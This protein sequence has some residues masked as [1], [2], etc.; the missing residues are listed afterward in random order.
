VVLFVPQYS[1]PRLLFILLIIATASP[2]VGDLYLP[3]LPAIADE[4]VGHVGLVKLSVSVFFAGLT[5]SILFFGPLS[6]HFERKHIIIAGFGLT[7]LATI[8]LVLFANAQS[9]IICRFIQGLGM[10]ATL[11]FRPMMRE[12]YAKQQLSVVGSYVAIAFSIT[13]MIIPIT[14][15]VIQELFDWQIN[16]IVLT[17]YLILV[18]FLI[19]WLLDDYKGKTRH[20]VDSVFAT[21]LTFI[22]NKS[23]MA[24]AFCAA[25]SFSSF[26]AYITVGPFIFQDTLGL[27]PSQ[28][29]L[30]SIVIVCALTLSS[31]LNKKW[32]TLYPINTVIMFGLMMQLSGAVLFLIISLLNY[33]TIISLMAPLFIVFV[34]YGLIFT[35]AF[36]GAFHSIQTTFGYATAVYGLAQAGVSSLVS[37]FVVLLP[38]T[39]HFSL[40]IM[41]IMVSLLAKLCWVCAQRCSKRIE[42]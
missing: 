24:Y 19:F 32:L 23:F 38:I 28:Y 25:F 6:D 17:V 39:A 8:L 10:G 14:G 36:V 12:Y 15:G 29:G 37:G 34:G 3:S 20:S 22:T 7:W 42:V 35:N 26:I 41:L 11:L 9:L 18:I 31:L 16:F 5:A 13:G 40:A 33:L 27:S 21:Y 2:V 4:F 1:Q 30:L